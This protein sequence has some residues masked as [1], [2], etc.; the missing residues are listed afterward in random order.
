M[1]V[2]RHRILVLVGAWA[3][4]PETEEELPEGEMGPVRTAFDVVAALRRLG[5]HVRVEGADEDL[6]AI[7]RA[8]EDHRPHV[9]FNLLEEFGDRG[10][11]AA[12]LVGWL[13]L[14]GRRYTGCR[15]MGMMLSFDKAMQRKILRYHRV[16]CPEFAI[17]RRGRT[18]RRP[19]RLSFPLIV[20]ALSLHGSIG[21]AHASVVHDDEALA[22]RVRF[23]HE[24]A[25]DDVIAEEYV[26][27]REIYLG[28]IGNE[29]LETFPL[30]E[31]R[32]EN[33]PEG[34]P[35]IATQK[36]KW[37][38]AYQVRSGTVVG[39]AEDLE[40]L[41]EGV[42]ERIARIGR[43][44]YRALEQTGYARLDLRLR[45]DGRVVLIES[46]PNPQLSRD[47]EF[48]LSAE[49]AG[50][51]YDRLLARIV[52]LGMRYRPQGR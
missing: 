2:R 15:P 20:K 5:H 24:H 14:V 45:P 23:M 47:G 22:E 49:A 4:P 33:L 25:Q 35:R 42:A 26:D 9:V 31:L 52:S 34:A 12:H 43:R 32:I 10:V 37:D 8:I 13:E 40:P 27:G 30:Y 51:D 17:F 3:M 50:L 46:N 39:P 16:P 18:I 44:A 41:P 48:A 28:M 29:R 21:I 7:R 11:G 1:S 19:G 36:V 6:G 38:L